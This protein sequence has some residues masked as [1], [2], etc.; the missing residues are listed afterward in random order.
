MSYLHS[1]ICIVSQQH[2]HLPPCWLCRPPGC[3]AL[4]THA[5]ALHSFLGHWSVDPAL[6]CTVQ[7]S[8]R[9]SSSLS[10]ILGLQPSLFQADDA[11]LLFVAEDPRATI[12]W[13]PLH[14]RVLAGWIVSAILYQDSNN[15]IPCRINDCSDVTTWCI[16]HLIVNHSGQWNRELV[17]RYK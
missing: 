12:V 9:E 10:Y 2:E 15:D 3:A 17:C 13:R 16:N 11:L 14:V 4:D 7:P 5:S 6:L 1:F 8:W